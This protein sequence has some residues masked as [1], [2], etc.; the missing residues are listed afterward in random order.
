[1]SS[2]L[3]FLHLMH[4]LCYWFPSTWHSWWDQITCF[5]P[6]CCVLCF[7]FGLSCLEALFVL[8]RK[9]MGENTGPISLLLQLTSQSHEFPALTGQVSIWTN[10]AEGH[11]KTKS[12]PSAL[13]F[14]LESLPLIQREC[15]L[16]F[17]PASGEFWGAD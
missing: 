16:W 1:M 7:C 12:C 5:H 11:Q 10:S 6:S 13:T 3:F 8:R 15:F 14:G 4:R 2:P 17:Y 9:I